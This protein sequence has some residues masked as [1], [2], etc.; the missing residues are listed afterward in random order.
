MSGRL[1]EAASGRN[2]AHCAADR[3]RKTLNLR[4]AVITYGEKMVGFSV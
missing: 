2:I 4:W 1:C 3:G